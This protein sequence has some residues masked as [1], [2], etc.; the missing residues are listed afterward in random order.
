[1]LHSSDRPE[2]LNRRVSTQQRDD[3][4]F[5]YPRRSVHPELFLSGYSISPVNTGNL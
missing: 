5:G 4:I 1:M 2:S 3:L